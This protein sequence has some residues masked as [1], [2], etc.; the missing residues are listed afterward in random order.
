MIENDSQGRRQILLRALARRNRLPQNRFCSGIVQTFHRHHRTAVV[1]RI[2]ILRRLAR[3]RRIRPPG[4]RAAQVHY[5][6]LCIR[7]DWRSAA[8]QHR[9]SVWIQLVQSQA[10]QLHKFARVI[11]VRVLSRRR[12]VIVHHVQEI[13]H[14][15][16]QG[17]IRHHIQ[18]ISQ[19]I[20]AECT[21]VIRV[22]QRVVHYVCAH[23]P[24]FV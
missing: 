20:L 3:R 13:S 19:R 2:V 7:R 16:S 4:E 18:V 6:V 9:R 12:R 14:R 17:H 5:V 11:F 22:P 1:L 24:K 15:R 23:H 10:E 8:V 21:Q